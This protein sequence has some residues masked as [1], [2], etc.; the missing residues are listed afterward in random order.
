M[1][2][3]NRIPRSFTHQKSGRSRKNRRS[4]IAYIKSGKNNSFI[5]SNVDSFTPENGAASMLFPVA[6]YRK[7]K[8][9]PKREVSANPKIPNKKAERFIIYPICFLKIIVFCVGKKYTDF[10][11]VDYFTIAKNQNTR[12]VSIFLHNSVA[13]NC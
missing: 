12:P 9:T 5:C 4:I 1:E 10:M 11:S 3:A 7:C 13:L 8:R 2:S 6:S